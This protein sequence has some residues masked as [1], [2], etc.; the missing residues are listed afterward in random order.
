MIEIEVAE[1]I[2]KVKE[3]TLGTAMI[4]GADSD[5]YSSMIR[6]LKNASMAGRDEWPKTITE[7]YNYLSKWEGDES[8]AR[9]TRDLEGFAFTNDTREPPPDRREPQAWN[10]KKTC[11]KFLKVGH[12]ATF[13]ENE[14]VSHINVQDGETQ[15]TSEEAVLELIV[16]EQEGANGDYYADLFLIEEQEHR[17]ASF[18]TKDGIN[19][20]QIPK[21]WILLDSQSTTDAFSNRAILK[22]IHEVQG[23]LTIHTQSGK[24]ITKLKLTVPR[25][26]EVWYCP[27]G[28]TNILSLAHVA[29][30]RLVRFDSTNRNQFE[31]TKDAGSTRIF[32]QSEHDI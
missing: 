8:S 25:Y 12:I 17:S 14:K 7:A 15:V 11:R 19:G 1:I 6:G 21:E 20:G 28:I 30:T 5:H 13:F 9:M 32:K 26:G 2:K 29:K 22:N 3:Y 16:A 24:S 27:N 31:V 18:H 23:S 4:L 10:A